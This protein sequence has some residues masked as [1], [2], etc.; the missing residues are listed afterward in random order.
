MFLM[1]V[2]FIFILHLRNPLIMC[3][4]FYLI[5]KCVCVCASIHSFMIFAL[6]C[7]FSIYIY[8]KTLYQ[9]V[10]TIH[11]VVVQVQMQ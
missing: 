1:L 6:Y 4:K 8:M 7:T 5:T 3:Y 10:Q 9:G 11:H 2:I